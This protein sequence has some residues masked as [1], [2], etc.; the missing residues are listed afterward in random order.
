[1]KQKLALGHQEFSEVIDNNCIYVDKT[2]TIH[3]LID[4]GSYYFSAWVV[5]YTTAP[6]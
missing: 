5:L 3:K 6:V 1:M 4:R 2:E